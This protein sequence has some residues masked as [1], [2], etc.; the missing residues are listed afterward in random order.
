MKEK[1]PLLDKQVIIYLSI[2]IIIVVLILISARHI[3]FKPW[4]ARHWA[5]PVTIGETAYLFGGV[6]DR[7]AREQKDFLEN[8]VLM[9]NFEENTLK[10]AGELPSRRYSVS[11]ARLN[12][13]IYIAGG[14]DL[15]SYLDEIL[16]YDFRGAG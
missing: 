2:L 8:D 7:N 4:T 11:S 13:T 3:L 9:I 12:G 1:S 10:R 14:Y 15:K 6:N 5:D 16:V